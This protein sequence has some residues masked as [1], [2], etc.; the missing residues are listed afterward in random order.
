MGVTKWSVRRERSLTPTIF[1]YSTE[2]MMCCTTRKVQMALKLRGLQAF[3]LHNY[4]YTTTLETYLR[5][6]VLSRVGIKVIFSYKNISTTI[7]Y[8]KASLIDFGTENKSNYK[9]ITEIDK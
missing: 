2:K 1:V 3:K 9:K 5:P 7:Q 4:F 8:S 6:I